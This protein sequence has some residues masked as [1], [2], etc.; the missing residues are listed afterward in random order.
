ML[1]FLPEI[2][3]LAGALLLLAYDSIVLTP[4]R[5]VLL[6]FSIITLA[7][8]LAS[9]FLPLRESLPFP[10]LFFS[11]SYL[12]DHFGAVFKGI[13]IASTGLVLLMN[14]DFFAAEVK[15]NESEFYFLILFCLL[16]MMI[17]VSS[18]NFLLLYLGLELLGLS[19]YALAG[20]Q[21]DISRSGEASLK[22]L[23]FGAASSAV[24]LYGISLIYGLFG[25]IDITKLTAINLLL[26][27]HFS[28]LLF[29]VL[30]IGFKVSMFPMQFWA[31]DVY[32]GAPTPFT[33]YISAAS[34]AMGVAVLFRLLTFLGLNFAVIISVF[35]ALTM[36][37]GNLTALRQRNIKRLLAYSSI[38]HAG[39]IL[40]AFLSLIFGYSAFIFYVAAYVLANLGAFAVVIY[41]SLVL[42]SEDIESYSGFAYRSPFTAFAL[43]IFFLSF[44][45]VP[46]LAGFVG[47]F[48]LFAVALNSG[49]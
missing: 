25:T 4:N 8:A 45:G 33:A 17:A 28:A 12:I 39:Y 46:P 27:L 31:P 32:E 42:K 47:K 49:Y 11:G 1:L 41:L 5:K 14:Y 34:K 48:L 19:S 20:W 3:V 36:F 23:F 6:W 37:W 44:I 26:P 43:S 7:L 38:S 13:F 22:Y 40:I 18:V 16:G 30:G 35:S 10:G 29:V 24:F 21:K 15:K 2:L 9:L